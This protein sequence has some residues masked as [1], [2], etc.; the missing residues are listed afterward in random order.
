MAFETAKLT[1]LPG[2]P[3]GWLELFS[4][5]TLLFK[6]I[7]KYREGDRRFESFG[8]RQ[9]INDARQP[10]GSVYLRL[11]KGGNV[12]MAMQMATRG[13]DDI[14]LGTV[15]YHKRMDTVMFRGWFFLLMADEIKDMM[16]E[17]DQR[18]VIREETRERDRTG[19]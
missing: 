9:R 4:Q 1:I 13:V 17:M 19:G 6:D 18:M 7:E 12:M 16:E 5:M 2:D 3:L 15:S 8:M 11:V 14:T 10:V